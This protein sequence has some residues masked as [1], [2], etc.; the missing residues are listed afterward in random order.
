MSLPRIGL[1]VA[2]SLLSAPA[3][4]HTGHGPASGLMAGFGHPFSGLDH[5]LVMGMVGIMA[6]LAGGRAVWAVPAGFLASM[7]AGGLI[8]LSG[9]GIPGAEAAI[10][11]SVVVAGL[12]IASGRFGSAQSIMALAAGFALFHGYAHGAEMPAGADA[13]AYGMGFLSASAGLLG[14]GILIGITAERHLAALRWL[15]AMVVVAAVV[16]PLLELGGF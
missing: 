5:V 7:V 13:A 14:A 15:S 9:V 16:A 8:G 6:A 2:L 10:A 11:A 12:V 3:L 4:A 1:A